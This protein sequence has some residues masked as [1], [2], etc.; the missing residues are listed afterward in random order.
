MER[1]NAASQGL[2]HRAAAVAQQS[3]EAFESQAQKLGLASQNALDQVN[4]A[5]KNLASQADAIAERSGQAFADQAQA[6]TAAS[7]GALEQFNAATVFASGAW[8]ASVGD[9]IGKKALA[10]VGDRQRHTADIPS[11]SRVAAARHFPK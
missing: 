4:A 8:L 3:G 6:L 9:I 5:A 2:T 10:Q 1:L 11:F 7:Q